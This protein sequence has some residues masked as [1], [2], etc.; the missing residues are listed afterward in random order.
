MVGAAV[1]GPVGAAV[2]AA[3]GGAVSLAKAFESLEDAAKS[4][5]KQLWQVATDEKAQFRDWYASTYRSE[6][7]N[8]TAYFTKD[9]KLEAAQKELW[10]RLEEGQ[11]DWQTDKEYKAEVEALQER[12]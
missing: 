9:G 7:T 3:V 2:G 6:I 10:K 12:V 11:A 1:G 4:A 5:S 8:G